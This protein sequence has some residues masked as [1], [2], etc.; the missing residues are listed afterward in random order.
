[1]KFSENGLYIER[2]V[3]CANCGVLIY[4]QDADKK[5]KIDHKEL[6]SDW[7]VTWAAEREKRAAKQ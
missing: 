1:M 6:C 7:C 3:K 4:P 2:Y 5:V